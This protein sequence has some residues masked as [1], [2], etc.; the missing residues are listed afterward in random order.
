MEINKKEIEVRGVNSK[1]Q[2]A[3]VL[4]IVSFNSLIGKLNSYAI[5]SIPI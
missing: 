3:I 1:Y 2:K 4:I 5:I